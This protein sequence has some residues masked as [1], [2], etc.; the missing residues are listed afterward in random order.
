VAGVER[1]VMA[2]AKDHPGYGGATPVAGVERP[3]MADAKDHPGYGRATPVDPPAEG[4]HHN[5]PVPV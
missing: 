3:V 2:D 5:L 4:R 1:P